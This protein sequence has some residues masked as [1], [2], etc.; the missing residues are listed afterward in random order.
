MDTQPLKILIIDDNDAQGN[1]L[2]ELLR[3]KEFDAT[4][5]STGQTGLDYV[6]RHPV[7]AILL[8][9]GLPDI[10]GPEICKRLRSDPRMEQTAIIYHTGS[11]QPGARS[12]AAMPF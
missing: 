2:A 11:S 3:L 10:S 6:Q 5:V 4:W 9:I 8:D 1:G 7:D 12:M